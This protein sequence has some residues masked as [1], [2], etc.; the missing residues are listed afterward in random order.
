M[1]RKYHLQKERGSIFQPKVFDQWKIIYRS[2]QRTGRPKMAS[3]PFQEYQEHII[4]YN[5]RSLSTLLAV[6]VEQYE[7]IVDCLSRA[8]IIG[9]Q[10]KALMACCQFPKFFM[11]R[12]CL[13]RQFSFLF[14][15][16]P[17]SS[18]VFLGTRVSFFSFSFLPLS[19]F[20]F[21]SAFIGFHQDW[22]LHDFC[23]MTTNQ[24]IFN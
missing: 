16:F 7:H 13:T 4:C 3:C 5:S 22:V 6:G 20:F 14:Y 17:P 24:D 23:T 10:S 2:F 8:Y 18:Q 19:P 11:K 9:C 15:F 1:H 12:K 21:L